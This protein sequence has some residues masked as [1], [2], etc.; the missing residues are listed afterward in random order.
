ML[1][2]TSATEKGVVVCTEDPY[3]YDEYEVTMEVAVPSKGD[4]KAA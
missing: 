1:A 2:E 4:T 3:G